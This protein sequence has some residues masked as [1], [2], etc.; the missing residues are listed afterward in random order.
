MKALVLVDHDSDKVQL[1]EVDRP[2][3]NANQVLV[4]IKAAVLLHLANKI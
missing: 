1:I 4:K 3:P 2:I